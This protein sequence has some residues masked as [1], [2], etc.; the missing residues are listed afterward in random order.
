MWE[1]SLREDAAE[2][3]LDRGRFSL[4]KLQMLLRS[5]GTQGLDAAEPMSGLKKTG[6]YWD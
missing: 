4:P 6:D 5:R 3:V 2:S 1:E